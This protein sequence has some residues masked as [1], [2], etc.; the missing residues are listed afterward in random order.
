MRYVAD[1][2][3]V[4]GRR[5][6]ILKTLIYEQDTDTWIRFVIVISTGILQIKNNLHVWLDLNSPIRT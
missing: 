5:L 2:G 3:N 4:Y 1:R 6:R